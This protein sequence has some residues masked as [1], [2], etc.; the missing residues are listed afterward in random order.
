MA[1]SFGPATS[2]GLV[3]AACEMWDVAGAA[4]DDSLSLASPL[5]PPPTA[6]QPATQP[7]CHPAAIPPLFN[8]DTPFLFFLVHGNGL[9]FHVVD[10]ISLQRTIRKICTLCPRKIVK[11]TGSST[12]YIYI[13]FL[14]D[15]GLILFSILFYFRVPV[16]LWACVPRNP[17][18]V[19]FLRNFLLLLLLFGMVWFGLVWRLRRKDCCAG[20]IKE[21]PSSRQQ[22]ASSKDEGPKT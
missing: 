20:W 15:F 8:G 4:N 10:F 21:G 17:I 12:I 5:Q 19:D 14:L 9:K 1:V 7:A 2:S 6:S 22:A 13:F 3:G 11:R 18:A 16:S